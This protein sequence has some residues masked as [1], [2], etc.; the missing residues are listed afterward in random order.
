MSKTRLTRGWLSNN[1]PHPSRPELQSKSLIL[2]RLTLSG[3]TRRPQRP[4]YPAQPR[5]NTEQADT[6][7]R[8]EWPES[9]ACPK[10]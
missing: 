6:V 4:A 1:N 5:V 8:V 3:H 10:Q 2:K 9:L 7:N